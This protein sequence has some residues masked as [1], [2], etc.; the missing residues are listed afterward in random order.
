MSQAKRLTHNDRPRNGTEDLQRNHLDCKSK[1]GEFGLH[2]F[3]DHIQGWFRRQEEENH[4]DGKDDE[5]VGQVV[6]VRLA[7]SGVGLGI[8]TVDAVA[9]AE[10]VAALV[11]AVAA[12]KA[13]I[14][15]LENKT[16][17]ELLQD[18]VNISGTYLLGANWSK[19]CLTCTLLPPQTGSYSSLHLQ[20]ELQ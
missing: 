18:V 10:V 8:R 1:G 12:G 13:R 6:A 15:E 5:E 17:S 3:G 2:R 20:S 16:S 7:D 19:E 9:V 4:Y 11:F 14:V